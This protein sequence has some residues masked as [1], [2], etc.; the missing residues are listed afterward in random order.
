M[1]R[2]LMALTLCASSFGVQAVTTASVTIGDP[3]ITVVD[4]APQDGIPAAYMPGGPVVDAFTQTLGPAPVDSFAEGRARIVRDAGNA[5]AGET[6][7]P[8][9]T[10][11]I[12]GDR[13]A[14]SF[15][16]TVTPHSRVTLSTDYRLD[17]NIAGERF[18]AEDPAHALASMDLTLVA[19]NNLQ[20]RRRRRRLRLRRDR[21]AHGRRRAGF[22]R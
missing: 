8:A 9:S 3:V 4:L 14:P 19:I 11:V 21:G 10:F 2:L 7:G 16:F 22:L 18:N 6:S 5:I 20:L 15:T 1:N 12:V 13:Y 17:T